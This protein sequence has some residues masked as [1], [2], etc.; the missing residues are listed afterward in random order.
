MKIT[1]LKSGKFAHPEPSKP[2]VRLV[3]GDSIEVDG[4][5][6]VALIETGWG[7]PATEDTPSLSR[8]TKKE[9]E[10][11]ADTIGLTDLDPNL[12]KADMVNEIKDHMAR[13]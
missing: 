9:L 2:T 8:M 4:K 13:V 1:A 5:M 7:E 6:A 11:Y 10:D 3:E 12:K